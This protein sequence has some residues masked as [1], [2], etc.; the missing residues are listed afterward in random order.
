M[1]MMKK[2]LL[3]T[4]LNLTATQVYVPQAPQMISANQTPVEVN[5]N[6]TGWSWF[7]QTFLTPATF[8]LSVVNLICCGAIIEG[9]MNKDK[10]KDNKYFPNMS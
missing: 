4:S 8:I 6:L 1:S 3:L 2:I 7:V 5:T 10:D 9:L